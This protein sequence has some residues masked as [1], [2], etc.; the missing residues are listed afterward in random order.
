M[1]DCVFVKAREAV[2]NFQPRQLGAYTLV[3][4][5]THTGGLIQ[6]AD[7]NGPQ[8]SIAHIEADTAPT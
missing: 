3:E 4:S 8:V 6:A 1:C 7:G 5:R 2:V